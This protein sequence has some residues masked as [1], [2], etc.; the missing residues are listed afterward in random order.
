MEAR[1]LKAREYNTDIV[2]HPEQN[3]VNYEA[4]TRYTNTNRS[5]VFHT[6]PDHQ[7]TKA[8]ENK[9][10]AHFREVPLKTKATRAS[11]QDSNIFN[12]KDAERG[13]VQ[14]SCVSPDK[15]VKMRATNTF[16]SSVFG[17]ATNTAP[18]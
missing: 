16:A 18:A 13:T 3:V 8:L 6:E 1:A 15:S 4:K 9:R 12:N 5:N 7:H 17:D 11:Y 2:S 14:A 10:E